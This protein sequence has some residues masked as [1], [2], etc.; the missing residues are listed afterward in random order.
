MHDYWRCRDS[1]EMMRYGCSYSK[2][3]TSLRNSRD[4][5]LQVEKDVERVCGRP[6]RF[7]AS[8]NNEVMDCSVGYPS[9]RNRYSISEIDISQTVGDL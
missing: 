9:I 4:V 5:V 7:S 2:R 8:V 6:P 3:K 1:N